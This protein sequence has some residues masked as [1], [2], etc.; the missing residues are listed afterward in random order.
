[1]EQENL[2]A[3][4]IAARMSERYA[5]YGKSRGAPIDSV[6]VPQR[7]LL[8][9][10]DDPTIWGVRCRPGKERE[11]VFAITKRIEQRFDT[12]TP[13]RITSA[14]E[15]GGTMAG[16]IYVE[17]R[18]K[19]D[20][21]TAV[22]GI[23]NV[24][25]SREMVLVPI[26]EMPDLLRTQKSKTID[27][28]MWVRIKRGKYQGDLAYVEEVQENG[29][30]VELKI[31][32]REDYGANEDANASMLAGI[33]TGAAAKRK[34]LGAFGKNLISSRPPPRLF[35]ENEA[36]KR[37]GR[38]LQQIDSLSSKKFQY[39]GNIYSGGYLIK[40]FKVQMLQTEDVNPTLEEVS[41]FTTG[42]DEGADTL[43]LQK[44][45]A[46]L[47]QT[48][49]DS[50]LP[51]DAV[52]IYSGEQRGVIGKA[53]SIRGEIV[54]L[55]VTD[56]DL[57]GQSVEAPVKDLRKRFR[58]GDHVKVIGGSKFIDE[59]GMVVRIKDHRVTLLSDSNNAEITVFSKDLRAATDSSATQTGGKYDLHDLVQLE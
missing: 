33:A 39:Q 43:D 11:I 54:T 21:K 52:E 38:Y 32:P 15:R 59:V 29:L 49:A 25:V 12:P 9:S 37:H 20:V 13:L 22:D 42:Q 55:K 31:V 4:Q 51:G 8:P 46:T 16:Y 36:R 2:T 26:Q 30:E 1:M 5:D 14:F 19:A 50:Y 57:K 56:G 17:A 58:E 45:A 7:L 18:T 53:V 3:E 28:G 34:R 27:P 35:N 44:L 47:K 48:T 23:I 6:V 24:F 41:K 10:V 40:M